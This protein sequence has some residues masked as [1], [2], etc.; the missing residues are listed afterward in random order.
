M[1]EQ[2]LAEELSKELE[3][4]RD[5]FVWMTSHELR[6]PLTVIIGYIDFLENM[7]NEIDYDSRK[8]IFETINSNLRRLER[9]TDEVSLLA[10]LERGIFN[11]DKKWTMVKFP[12][13]F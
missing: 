6:T 13:N 7:V 5:N 3:E 11:I 8:K 9:L 4:R 2:K 12:C 1:T 10:Q